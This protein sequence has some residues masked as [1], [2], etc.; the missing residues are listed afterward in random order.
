MFYKQNKTTTFELIKWCIPML[1]YCTILWKCI[2]ALSQILRWPISL[3]GSIL[4]TTVTEVIN[5]SSWEPGS[6]RDNTSSPP[7]RVTLTTL[8][9]QQPAASWT[10]IIPRGRLSAAIVIE[11]PQHA[12]AETWIGSCPVSALLN[13]H[14]LS[15]AQ[16][17]NNDGEIIRDP[18]S[19]VHNNL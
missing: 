6:E 12:L 10:W 18:S 16:Q 14:L 8:M 13:Q 15:K 5:S 11:I 17:Q 2:E 19:G 9:K 7:G 1:Y 4:P 3:S